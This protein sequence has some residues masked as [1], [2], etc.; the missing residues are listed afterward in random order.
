MAVTRDFVIDAFLKYLQRRPESE[1]AIVAHMELADEAKVVK[2]LTESKEYFDKLGLVLRFDH[3]AANK[4]LL[5]G[6]CQLTSI[7]KLIEAMSADTSAIAIELIS[8][9]LTGLQNGNFDIS[10]LVS[11][12]DYVVLQ[13]LPDEAFSLRLKELY[14]EIS[15]KIRM[16]PGIS[17][18]AFHPD[19][20]YIRKASGGHLG[21][22]M[23]EYHSMLVF[24]AWKNNFT[25]EMTL[26]LFCADT[27]K[28]LGY[29]DHLSASNKF[30]EERGSLT[31]TPI[32]SLVAHWSSYGCF[33][34][35]LNHP[36]LYVLADIA[37]LI[38]SR[39]GISYID[40]VESFIQDE[41]AEHPCWP[42][43]PA[44]GK[45]LGLEGSYNFKQAK[46]EG[47]SRPISIIDLPNFIKRSF[48]QYNKNRDAGLSGF[49]LDADPF[50]ALLDY[51]N[52][53]SKSATLQKTQ[54]L[55]PR[56]PYAGLQNYQFWRRAIEAVDSSMVDPVVGSKF[57]LSVSDKVATAGSC[58]AQHISRTL[59]SNGFTYYV[60]ETGTGVDDS[61]HSL[62][63]LNYGV[64]SARYGNIYTSRQ[65]VQLFDRAYGR[66]SP[67]DNAWRRKDGRYVDPFRPL[68]EPLGYASAADVEIARASHFDS[69]REMFENMTVFVFTLGLTEAWRRKDDGAV[70]P[71][72]PGVAAGAMD[73]DIYEFVNFETHEVIEDLQQFLLRLESVNADCK[74]ILTVSPV[75]L[76]AT[77]EQRHVLASTTYSKSALRAAAD[78]IVRRYS[79]CEYFPSY[80]IITGNFSRGAYFEADLRSVREE[81]VGHVMRLFMEHYS[82]GADIKERP[83]VDKVMIA[84]AAMNNAIVCDEEALDAR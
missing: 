41:L 46:S 68:V 51:V 63:D 38:L 13:H 4:I 40:G 54:A 20:G 81:G 16:V 76:I 39:E 32:R 35:S 71:L 70:F 58:F 33:M 18:T 64:F 30:L 8:R 29:L 48:E 43:Y 9:N 49:R 75:P 55:I 52:S 69:V 36:K 17:Y 23:G 56:N 37:R 3:S 61:E 66:F 79:S 6:N 62:K 24:W 14:P 59:A 7:G 74:V 50:K 47:G 26:E 15:T 5:I 21:G 34:H 22:P 72:A 57:K 27:F 28:F 25:L 73:G 60:T 19:M 1:Q 84:E 44:I 80:E 2:V 53:K 45:I 12:C 83:E 77:Y 82:Q 11:E 31:N 42:V 10:E 78:H 67:L 65:L